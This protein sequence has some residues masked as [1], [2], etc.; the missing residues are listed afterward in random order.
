LE[1][2]KMKPRLL[3]SI[4]IGLFALA[5]IFGC[6]P[7]AATPPPVDVAG[8]IAVQLASSMLSQTAAAYS[9][10]PLPVTPTFTPTIV[11]VTPTETVYVATNRPKISGIGSCWQ[12]GPGPTY[13]YNTLSSHLSDSKK[14]DLLGVGSV[15]GWYI[16]LHPNFHVPCWIKA[17]ELQILSDIDLSTYPIMTPGPK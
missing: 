9:P 8:T 15:P 1:K 6:T 4:V 11:P 10:T 12:G 7:K 17:E 3:Y 13:G 2:K 14:V 16:I 5:L